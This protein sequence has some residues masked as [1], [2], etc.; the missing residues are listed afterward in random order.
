[1]LSLPD[2]LVNPKLAQDRILVVP[3]LVRKVPEPMRKIIGNLS[4]EE[5]VLRVSR[6]SAA[7]AAHEVQK[8]W[9]YVSAADAMSA[10]ALVNVR[11][12]F[13]GCLAGRYRLRFSTS[14]TT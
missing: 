2:L 5:Q 6:P 10:R 9:L 11:R 8:F 13:D 1:M 7:S 14:V 12:S 3:T 4:D